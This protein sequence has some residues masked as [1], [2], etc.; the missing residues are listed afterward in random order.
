MS[1][2]FARPLGRKGQAMTEVVL[3]FPIVMFFLFAFA[4]VFALLIL[5]QKLEIA[6]FNAARRWQL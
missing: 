5:M 2:P 3:L 6:S 4:K 1:L